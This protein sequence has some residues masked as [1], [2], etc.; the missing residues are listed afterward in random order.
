MLTGHVLAGGGNKADEVLRERV[1]DDEWIALLEALA[2]GARG[3][4]PALEFEQ[5]AGI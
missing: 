1:A 3:E 2:L 5:G 4:P